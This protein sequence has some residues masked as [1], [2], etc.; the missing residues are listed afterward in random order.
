M[1]SERKF[2]IVKVSKNNGVGIDTTRKYDKLIIYDGKKVLVNF[3]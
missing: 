3:F 2:N 1:L